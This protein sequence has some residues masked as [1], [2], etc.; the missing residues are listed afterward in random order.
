MEK[1]PHSFPIPGCPNLRQQ[2]LRPAP[3]PSVVGIH[4]SGLEHD[5]GGAVHQGPVDDVGVPSD[6]AY[7]SH[8]GED[9][10][11][12]QAKRVLR[13]HRRIEE[14]SRRGVRDTLRLPRRPRGVE[15]EK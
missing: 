5:G 13:R 1:P 12:L 14:V 10:S 11:V 7:I 6:P 9:V 4:G 15:D 8:T 3:L 2:S